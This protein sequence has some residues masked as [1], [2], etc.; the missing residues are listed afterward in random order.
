MKTLNIVLIDKYQLTHNW[1]FFFFFRLNSMLK[2]EDA[3]QLE[4]SLTSQ[5]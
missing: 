4:T 2:I 1:L 5:V 3:V